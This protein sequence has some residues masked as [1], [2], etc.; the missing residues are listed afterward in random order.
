M[1]LVVLVPVVAAW[2]LTV[3]SWVIDRYLF[4]L[5]P[6][7]FLATLCA[8]VGVRRPGLSVAIPAVVVLAGFAWHLQPDFLWAGDV[9]VSFDSPP[10]RLYRPLASLGDT[11][12]VLVVL[13][14]VL[15]VLFVA[16]SRLLRPPVLTAIVAGLLLVALPAGTGW[17][18]SE[19]LSHDGHS[20]RPLTRDESGDLDWLDRAVGTGA[21]VTEVPYP[22]S[23]NPFVSQ[24]AWR[25]LEF[26]NKS[27]RYAVHYPTPKHLRRRRDLVPEQ[28]APLRPEHG[29]GERL[30]LALRAAE[31]ERDPIPGVGQ[32]AGRAR[33]RDADRRNATV[34][35]RLAHLRALRRRLDEARRD[36]PDQ[37]VRGARP[38]R[39]GHARALA[40]DSG[41]ERR[42]RP[43]RSR[44]ARTSSACT[45]PS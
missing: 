42:R 37:G 25:D 29:R 3:G 45:G 28:R 26:W 33:E 43:T 6:I 2:D 5:A 23:S 19:L 12:V 20:A 4:Y 40:P 18:F 30:A 36:G 27:V 31:R 22:M 17:T 32:R 13:T 41:A 8:L 24:Q 14:V 15:A 7:L 9:P 16:G 34:A 39:A 38:T 21:V 11:S 35:E 44:S 1:L 10:S